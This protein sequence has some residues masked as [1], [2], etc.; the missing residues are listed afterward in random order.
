MVDYLSEK[1]N[2]NLEV[3]CVEF[4]SLLYLAFIWNCVHM[5]MEQAVYHFATESS[6]LW[7]YA[8]YE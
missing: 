1:A 2:G 7:G 6:H 5:S 8:S 3:A 4:N